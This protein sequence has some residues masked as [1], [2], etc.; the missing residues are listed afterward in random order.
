MRAT[1]PRADGQRRG[2]GAAARRDAPLAG[3]LRRHGPRR[4]AAPVG[5]IHSSTAAAHAARWPRTRA[6]AVSGPA[7]RRLRCTGQRP[8]RTRS[9]KTSRLRCPRCAGPWASG[10]CRPTARRCCMRGPLRPARGASPTPFCGC[11]TGAGLHRRRR[12]RRHPSHK[13]VGKLHTPVQHARTQ[14]RHN[15]GIRGLWPTSASR[16]LWAQRGLTSRWQSLAR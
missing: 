9:C 16:V 5:T 1:V 3:R 8:A 6:D 2:V 10:P 4:R 7:I 11:P 15:Y 12:R 14:E 13:T